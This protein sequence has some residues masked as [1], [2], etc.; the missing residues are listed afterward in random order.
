M[1]SHE[2]VAVIDVESRSQTSLKDCGA[3]KYAECPTTQVL[4][5]AYRLPTWRVGRTGLW[6]SEFRSVGL[7][8]RID[9]DLLELFDWV[10]SGKPVEAHNASFEQAIW[11]HKLRP[12]HWPAIA[13]TQWRC[14]MAK[15][16]AAAL[17]RALSDAADALGLSI[18]KDETGKAGMRKMAAPRK[19]V[20]D[21][22]IQWAR[23]HDPCLDCNATGKLKTGRA[24]AVPCVTCG[25]TGALSD[26]PEMPVLYHETREQLEDLFA[27]C[28]QDVLAEE[29]LS[30]AVPDLSPEELAVYHLD[31]AVNQRG[32]QLDMRGVACALDLLAEAAQDLNAQLAVITGGMVTRATQRVKLMSWLRTQGVFLDDTQAATIDATLTDQTVQGAAREALT[33]LRALGRSSTA[34]YETMR[35]WA[36]HDGRVRGGLLYHGATTGRWSG[37]GVQPHNFPRGGGSLKNVSQDDLWAA[38]HTGDRATVEALGA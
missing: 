16:S 3:W 18:T 26:G 23:Q 31:Q 6:H 37:S 11:H 20:K 27:Y 22:R 10:H 9:S 19:P 12:T 17:P 34:K 28:R 24:K 25:G 15:A 14:S 1:S 5:M 30:A 21:E 33:T 36:G 32:F 4:C 7:A 38:V 8:E 35:D 13:L 2:P 29:A